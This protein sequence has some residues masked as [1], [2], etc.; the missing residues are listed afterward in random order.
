MNKEKRYFLKKLVLIFMVILCSTNFAFANKPEY[1]AELSKIRTIKKAQISALNTQIRDITSNITELE[2]DTTISP[3]EK[4]YKMNLY[5]KKLEDL[6][7]KKY[8]ISEKYK[9]DKATLKKKYK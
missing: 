5:T 8:Q 3:S 9:K 1:D 2:L 6:T 7:S 4:E